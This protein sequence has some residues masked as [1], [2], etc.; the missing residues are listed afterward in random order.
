MVSMAGEHGLKYGRGVTRVV[1]AVLVV[2]ACAGCSSSSPVEGH[3]LSANAVL[4]AARPLTL[5]AVPVA[6]LDP[7]PTDCRSHGQTSEGT[8]PQIEGGAYYK[9]VNNRLA[10][11]FRG[12]VVYSSLHREHLCFFLSGTPR[13]GNGVPGPFI[14]ASSSL[15]SFMAYEQS[16]YW[17]G[18]SNTTLVSF[19]ALLP[20]AHPV[21]WRNLF[22][23]PKAGLRVVAER[24][25]RATIV[26]GAPFGTV[27]SYMSVIRATGQ[28][29]L[30]AMGMVVGYTP[31]LGPRNQT[32]IFLP[33]SRLKP[34]LSP[35]GQRLV[36]A[37][38]VPRW[39]LG[40]RYGR[41]R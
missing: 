26:H 23:D 16:N 8:Y 1:A 29:A 33:Y 24:V 41:S 7:I 35:T 38:A 31:L 27:A 14:S 20:S 21:P 25:R 9:E 36:S 34:L 18:V 6:R 3:S 32:T 10:K 11:F 30:T 22:A 39:T 12:L 17:D 2:L 5:R 40:S 19:S 37:I 4:R 28:F 15:V 13:T